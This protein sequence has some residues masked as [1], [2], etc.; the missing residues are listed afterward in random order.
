MRRTVLWILAIAGGLVGLVLIAVA[1]A[2]A[3]VDVKTLAGPVQARVK[4]ET[5]RD[6][7]FGGPI[8]LTLS[9]EP[10][11]IASDVTLSNAPWAHA[12]QMA[13]VKRVEVQ[14]ALLPLLQKRFEVVEVA[15][16]EPTIA[17]ETDAQ[18]RA[19]WEFGA[20]S[21]AP[22]GATAPPPASAAGVIAIGNVAIRDGTLT[23]RDGATGKT[24]NVAIE[25]L[26]IRS[27]TSDAPID[28][29][30][31]GRIDDVAVAVSGHLGPLDALRER[32]WP[33]PVAIKGDIN[34]KPANVST[35]I[36]M[37]GETTTLDA[38]DLTWGSLTLKGS[39]RVAR[40]NGRTRYEFALSSPAL[41]LEDA[42]IA[43]AAAAGAA[44]AQK[45]A[46]PS[47]F[48]ISDRPLP[49]DT[50]K[51]IDLDGT[52]AIGDLIIDK[53][54]RLHAVTLKLTNERGKLDVPAFQASG[55]GGTLAGR[56][57]IDAAA[58]APAVRLHI[59][60]RDLDLDALLKAIGEARQVRGGKTTMTLDIAARGQSLHAWAASANGQALVSVG[61][62][63]LVNAK[64]DLDDVLDKL[65]SSV[66]PYRQR[67]PSTEI[68]CAVIRL[69]LA[70][71]VARVDRSIAMETKKIAV[72]ASGTLDF[73][74]ERLDFTL[75]PRIREGIPLDLPT[76]AELVH[77]SGP[78]ANP[79]V[80]L[81]AVRSAA[82]MAKI[83]AAISTGGLSVLG[84]SLIAKAADG[85]E[86]EI[87]LGRQTASA[88]PAARTGSEPA[89]ASAVGNEIG[90]ALGKL[91]GR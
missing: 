62:A 15:L 26:A 77:F 65:S 80:R 25:R 7:V 56:V 37:N 53:R 84:T 66:N 1:I 43:G 48:V 61:P 21:A 44:T 34:G 31:K 68:V 59:E 79:A 71:G 2:V 13:Q 52:L 49:L 19:N 30:F 28:A 58:S 3:T 5:G 85:N 91:F 55:Y 29:E 89:P 67:D 75:R 72:S 38:L 11:L 39:L 51:G 45:S 74:D 4:A 83:G 87:A 90:K 27:R 40:A 82:T 14:V 69:P 88:N 6:L 12:P 22:T 50:L 10:K 70:D 18:G 23:Y 64:L 36:G 20:P 86:C 63:T 46:A 24:T 8:D 57:S 32:R 73:R 78:F 41:S 33:Y 54:N 35:K 81:D 9:L 47:R 42:A 17:L 60:G 16:V 76:F